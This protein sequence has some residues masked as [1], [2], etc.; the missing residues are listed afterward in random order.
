[1]YQKIFTFA[2]ILFAFQSFAQGP[3]ISAKDF[4]AEL[5]ANKNMVV[6]DVNGA[7]IYGKQHIQGA[8]N[9][10]HKDLYK[11]GAVE[12]QIKPAEELAAIFGKKGV[13]N[14]AKIV[15]YDEGSNRYNSRVWWILKSIGATDVSILHFNMDQFAA[16]RIPLTAT[17]SSGKST[18]FIVSESP[19]KAYTMPDIQ[20]LA[21]GT[22][23][24]DAREKDEFEGADAAKKSKGHL[25]RAIWM[26]FKEVLTAAG[27]YKSKD[28]IIAAAAKFGATPEKPIIVYCNS[29]IKAAVVFI[30]L[31][32]IAGFQN[33]GNYVGSYADWA[34]VPE[35][36]IVK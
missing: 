22:V 10:P 4:A 31:K 9:L 34:T 6:I 19:Y 27:D 21:E 33:V 29:G 3:L 1:M 5:K 25:P 23:L 15:L 28:E 2:L 24:L 14:T 30:A 32:E 12:G 8:I 16:A 36:Q 13:S 26:N 17:P 11:P 35:N 18:T 7:D 20:K